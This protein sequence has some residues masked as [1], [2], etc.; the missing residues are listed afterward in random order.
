MGMKG[1]RDRRRTAGESDG[2]RRGRATENGGG[3]RRRMEGEI[4]GD[5][6]R[7]RFRREGE[8]TD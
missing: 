4:D 2:E 7:R 8:H 3:E 5:E 6:T 1:R